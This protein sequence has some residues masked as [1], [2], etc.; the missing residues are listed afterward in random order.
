MMTV[1]V[2][3]ETLEK[4]GVQVVCATTLSREFRLPTEYGLQLHGEWLQAKVEKVVL[5]GHGQLLEVYVGDA[6]VETMATILG[7]EARAC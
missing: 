5:D 3:R 6:S 1:S 2:S 7:M 4:Q